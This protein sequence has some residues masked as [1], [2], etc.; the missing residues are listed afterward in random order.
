M[1]V[2]YKKKQIS[3]ENE[4]PLTCMMKIKVTLPKITCPDMMEEYENILDVE[5][6]DR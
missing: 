5:E 6:G 1:E 4:M 3:L 2:P